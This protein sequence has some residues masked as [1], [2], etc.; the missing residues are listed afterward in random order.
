LPSWSPPVHSQRFPGRRLNFRPSS[1]SSTSGLNYTLLTCSRLPMRLLSPT[2]RPLSYTCCPAGAVNGAIRTPESH[3]AFAAS[4]PTL[5]DLPSPK[6][7]AMRSATL[8]HTA[9]KPFS[10]KA[11]LG[12][13]NA[14]LETKHRRP[15][16]KI[17]AHAV[18]TVCRVWTSATTRMDGLSQP[19]HPVRA[20]PTMPVSDLFIHAVTC[21]HTCSTLATFRIS[22]AF[23]PARLPSSI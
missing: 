12:A 18:V 1:P 22:S 21:S 5:L 7:A 14:G 20:I 15:A 10:R 3:S 23:R 9:I 19:R 13:H 11:V 17:R 16:R 6:Q 2:R 4:G 8:I